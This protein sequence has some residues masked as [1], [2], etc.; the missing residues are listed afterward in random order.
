MRTVFIIEDDL[1]LR[2]IYKMILGF[3]GFE[4]VGSAKNGVEAIEKIKTMSPKPSIIL[5]DHRMPLKTG[6][7][8]TK[9]L[10]SEYAELKIIFTSADD[11]I[12]AEAIKQGAIAF[13]KKP[14]THDVLIHTL[15][16]VLET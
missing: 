2:R 10:L 9:I 1:A 3:K 15:D 4:V 14:F 5:M 6:L 12:E 8:T 13:L 16:S 11:S 7:E